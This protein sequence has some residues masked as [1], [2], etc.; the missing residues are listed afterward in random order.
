MFIVVKVVAIK[1]NN[2]FID[3]I[4]DLLVHAVNDKKTVHFECVNELWLISLID[5]RGNHN[6]TNNMTM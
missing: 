3:L 4:S 1:C 5:K 2:V 6:N